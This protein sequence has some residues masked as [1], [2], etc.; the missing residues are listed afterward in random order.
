MLAA[1]VTCETIGVIA[2]LG[3]WALSGTWLG[4]GRERMLRWDFRLQQA[5]ARALLWS[6]RR[7]FSLRVEVERWPSNLDRGPVLVFIRH[8]SL[9]DTLLPAALISSRHG[10]RLRYVL[11]RELL[12]DPCIDIIASRLPNHFAVRDSGDPREAGAVAHLAEG[13]GPDEGVL[14]YPEGTR[15]SARKRERVLERLAGAGD[16]ALLRRA[17]SLKRVLPPRLGG[18]LALLDAAPEADVVFV[19]HQGL[20]GSERPRDLW[21]GAMIG[22]PIR[23]A[24]W[25][26]PAQRIPESREGRVE[27]LYDNWAEIDRWLAGPAQ[28]RAANGAPTA[29]TGAGSS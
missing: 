13:L 4:V 18:P 21:R 3:T 20:E 26:V 17:T 7:A 25:R 16:P 12:W 10:I 24:A 11:K 1:Y 19:A 9:L 14:I 2:S 6:V 5:W 22:R 28:D 8:A 15:F 23:I 27:W 29:A